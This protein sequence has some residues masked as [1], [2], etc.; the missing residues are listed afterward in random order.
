MLEELVKRLE[1]KKTVTDAGYK[2]RHTERDFK[3]VMD[4]TRMIDSVLRGAG[5]EV[6]LRETQPK[7]EMEK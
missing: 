5:I 6:V 4:A 7:D 1:P 3:K 2:G